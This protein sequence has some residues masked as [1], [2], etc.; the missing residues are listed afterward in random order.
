MSW[1]NACCELYPNCSICPYDDGD[2]I[3]RKEYEEDRYWAEMES[4]WEADNMR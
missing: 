4:K 1:E 2:Y 3:E